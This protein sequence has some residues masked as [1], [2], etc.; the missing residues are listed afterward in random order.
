VFTKLH[1]GVKYILNI[2][3]SVYFICFY[4]HNDVL[5]YVCDM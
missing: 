3:V 4:P 5:Y 1:E 2:Y